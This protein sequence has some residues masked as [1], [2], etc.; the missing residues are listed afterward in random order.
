M[1]RSWS[2]TIVGPRS[3]DFFAG[4][5]GSRVR[6]PARPASVRW[7]EIAARA[8]YV[9]APQAGLFEPRVKL[10]ATVKKGDVYGW[11]HF[12]D[13]PVRAPATVRFKAT[14]LLSCMRHPGRCERGDCLG[15]L[16]SDVAS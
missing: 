11:V 2:N 5:R 16:V 7:V 6:V 1:Q 10:G 14:G 8:Y 4:R 13:D 9:Y 15:H 12:I 3:T